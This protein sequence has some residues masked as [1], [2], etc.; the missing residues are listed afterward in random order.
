MSKNKSITQ[1]LVDSGEIKKLGKDKYFDHPVAGAAIVATM[2]LVF[3]VIFQI[4]YDWSALISMS[5]LLIIAISW[6][7]VRKRFKGTPIS[8][9][10]IL[11]TMLGGAAP[12]V[13]FLMLKG[14][15]G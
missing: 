7:Y 13:I 11:F 15:F 9:D 4:N 2:M 12:L 6:E 5:S 10:D 3:M 1:D 14:L 8:L